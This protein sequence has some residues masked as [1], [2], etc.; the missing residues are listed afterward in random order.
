MKY[1]KYYLV[2][3]DKEKRQKEYI[4][5]SQE[6]YDDLAGYEPTKFTIYTWYW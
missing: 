6:Q 5:M 2:K 4:P 3:F 1:I